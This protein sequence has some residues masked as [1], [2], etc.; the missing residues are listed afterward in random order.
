[1]FEIHLKN[2]FNISKTFYTVCNWQ[3]RFS[4]SSHCLKIL[5]SVNILSLGKKFVSIATEVY[6]LFSENVFRRR[7]VNSSKKVINIYW[8]KI[9]VTIKEN[10]EKRSFL[11]I[12]TWFIIYIYVWKQKSLKYTC[13][14]YQ[15]TKKNNFKS[16]RILNTF[17]KINQKSKNDGFEMMVLWRF[18]SKLNF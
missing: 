14:F 15:L 16:V 13:A 18:W 10:F 7:C 12:L 4:W 9:F 11:T 3:I 17:V 1:M 5:H 2:K 6:I 8:N